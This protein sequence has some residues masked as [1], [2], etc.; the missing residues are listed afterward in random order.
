[1]SSFLTVVAGPSFDADR[2]ALPFKV[3][4]ELVDHL[5]LDS[6]ERDVLI[7]AAVQRLQ[8]IVKIPLRTP[9]RPLKIE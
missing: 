2:I 3:A 4:L 1:M 9:L 5:S 6:I 8:E 7:R